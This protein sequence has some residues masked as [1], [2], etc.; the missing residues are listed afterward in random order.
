[1][2]DYEPMYNME[3]EVVRDEANDG[4]DW[5]AKLQANLKAFI[6]Y[7]YTEEPLSREKLLQIIEWFAG[8]YWFNN[9]E[10]PYW[11]HNVPEIAEQLTDKHKSGGATSD[12][13]NSPKQVD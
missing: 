1:M 5:G 11:F 9:D 2:S 10:A 4:D 13:T 6:R 12:S 3:C 8:T 7:N